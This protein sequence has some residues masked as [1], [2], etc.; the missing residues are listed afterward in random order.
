MAFYFDCT[1]LGSG[2]GG[3]NVDKFGV[4]TKY[5]VAFLNDFGTELLDVVSHLEN[6]DELIEQSLLQG[7]S[8]ELGVRNAVAIWQ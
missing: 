5:F 4:A 8:V 6:P 7:P 2:F 1:R 3:L